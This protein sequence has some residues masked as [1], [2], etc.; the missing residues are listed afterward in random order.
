MTPEAQDILERF[1]VRGLRAAQRLRA[2]DLAG[3]DLFSQRLVDAQWWL[4][5]NGYI[6]LLAE[7]YELTERGDRYLYPESLSMHGARVFSNGY[8]VLVQQTSLRGYPPGVRCGR[9]PGTPRPTG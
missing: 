8:A 9:G 3:L 1:R 7:G 4:R 6:N 2:D 5:D